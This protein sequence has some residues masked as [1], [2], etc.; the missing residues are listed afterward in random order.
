MDLKNRL[1]KADK[2]LDEI[3]AKLG[4]LLGLVGAA[5]SALSYGSLIIIG[6]VTAAVCASYLYMK[7]REIGKTSA[8]N[9]KILRILIIIFFLLLTFS[10]L[11][12]HFAEPY[13]IPISFYIAIATSYVII[14]LEIF[15][16]DNRSK[17]RYIPL[18]QIL[19]SSLILRLALYYQ[20]PSILGVDP[21]QTYSMLNGIIAEGHLLPGFMYTNF[22]VFPLENVAFLLVTGIGYKD[23]L[24]FSSGIIELMSIVL[25]FLLGKTICDLKTGLLA[26]LVFSFSSAYIAYGTHSIIA[27]SIGIMLLSVIAYLII[28]NY[29]EPSLKIN[30][31]IVIL[32]GVLIFTHTVAS[33][34]CLVLLLSFLL[35]KYIYRLLE[36]KEIK[37]KSVTLTITSL[38]GIAMIG[39]WMFA[40]GFFP[41]ISGAIKFAFQIAG[42]EYVPSTIQLEPGFY[43]SLFGGIQYY[44]TTLLLILGVLVWLNK[45]NRS[46][47]RYSLLCFVGAVVLITSFAVNIGFDAI[48]PTRWQPFLW[49]FLS[50]FICFPLLEISKKSRR[51]GRI[52]TVSVVFILGFIMIISNMANIS[53]PLYEDKSRPALE[54]SEMKAADFVYLYS[55]ETIHTDCYYSLYFEFILNRESLGYNSSY[56]K[57]DTIVP[58]NTSLVRDYSLKN[59]FLVVGPPKK[60]VGYSNT[61]FI[62]GDEFNIRAFESASRIYDC[63]SIFTYD[64]K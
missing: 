47:K 28:K 33:M 44:I 53:S 26:S 40:S 17:L 27:M 30:A 56:F 25:I 58:I 50:I 18:V 49:M 20:F 34:I 16:I 60:D 43:E 51:T 41:Y 5:L 8:A 9:G 32:L 62:K 36:R 46:L 29:D 37:G 55:N 54:E 22:P 57:N 4:I 42:G 10:I 15:F 19:I 38:F 13:V 64:G 63:G 3:L 31:I 14:V 11:T 7:R 35:S 12:I 48:L 6:L 52:L 61:T 59:Y 23:S 21:Y 45:Y 1:I 39:Y 2:N 24:F